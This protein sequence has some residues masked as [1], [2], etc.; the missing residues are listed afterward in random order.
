M[1]RILLDC[2]LMEKGIMS[3]LFRWCYIM[4]RGFFFCV[5]TLNQSTWVVRFA[6][7]AADQRGVSFLYLWLEDTSFW[8]ITLVFMMSF[9]QTTTAILGVYQHV[10]IIDNAQV[11]VKS[12]NQDNYKLLNLSLVFR[13]QNCMLTHLS[14]KTLKCH[15]L[16][17]LKQ[18][19]NK[20]DRQ[21]LKMDR[22]HSIISTDTDSCRLKWF[23]P[24]QILAAHY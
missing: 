24:I 20:S 18:I 10:L 14:F 22:R 4:S 6:P 19:W 15:M 16:P 11:V 9:P 12:R 3:W 8:S 2:D 5:C 21:F 17:T 7:V 23:R 13:S 1:L